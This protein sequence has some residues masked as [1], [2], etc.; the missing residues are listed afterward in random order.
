M[1]LN[2]LDLR[3]FCENRLGARQDHTILDWSRPTENLGAWKICFFTCISAGHFN[4][5]T[6]TAVLISGEVGQFALV[7]IQQLQLGR[8]QLLLTFLG[9]WKVFNI[10]L[11]KIPRVFKRTGEKSIGSGVV[12]RVNPICSS[13]TSSR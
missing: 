1:M 10:E 4:G 5:Q 3:N 13:K 12:V 9:L 11:H 8:G 7:V 2:R 6:P